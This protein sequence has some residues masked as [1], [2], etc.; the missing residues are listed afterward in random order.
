MNRLLACV[1]LLSSS[2]AVADNA[3]KADALFDKGKRLLAEKRYGDACRTLEEVDKL[4]PGIGVKLNIAKCY[5][6]WGR[7]ATAYSWYKQA[8]ATAM[9]KKDVRLSQIKERA[10][11]LDT[12]VPRLTVNVPKGANPDIVETITLDGNPLEK[13][14][15]NRA[16]RVDPGP[17]R[18]EYVVEAR[19]K[20]RAAALERGGSAEMTLDIPSGPGRPKTPNKRIEIGTKSDIDHRRRRL[21][22]LTVAGGGVVALGIA[23]VLTLTARSKYNDALDLHCMGSTTACTPTGVDLTHSARTR[24]DVATVVSIGG[25]AL[26]TTGIVLYLTAPDGGDNRTVYVAP[27]LG[28]NG[29]QLVFGGK[30]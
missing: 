28:A 2:A 25:V 29:G 18:V 3:A 11:A 6:E 12:Y 23:G 5:E 15:L 1:L 13:S 4:D 22:G 17:H 10:A 14:K 8:L 9:A 7:L 24:A 16:Q 19:T 26:V 30:F 27:S 20:S 21:L